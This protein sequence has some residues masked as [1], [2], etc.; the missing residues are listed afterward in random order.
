M[1]IHLCNGA[2]IPADHTTGRAEPLSCPRPAVHPSN[3]G[4]RRPA[5]GHE[6]TLPGPEQGERVD[7]GAVQ[8]RTPVEV[9]AAGREQTDH[10][11]GGDPVTLLDEQRF[12]PTVRRVDVPVIDGDPAV[13][14]DPS[15]ERHDAGQDGADL[16]AGHRGE[17]DAAMS[18]SVRAAR[19]REE[20]NDLA[21]H[22]THRRAGRA[23]GRDDGILRGRLRPEQRT[24]PERDEQQ[25]EHAHGHHLRT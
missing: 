7:V 3:R 5:G 25:R 9:V 16:L 22:G 6:P 21:V 10:V 20:P 1:R 17:V 12:E 24:E 23:G 4:R 18:G 15:G 19:R 2:D 13:P 14:G 8:P 11:A